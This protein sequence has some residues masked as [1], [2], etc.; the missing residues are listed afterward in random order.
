MSEDATE[1]WAERFSELVRGLVSDF[2]DYDDKPAVE[3]GMQRHSEWLTYSLTDLEQK[4][5]DLDKLYANPEVALFFLDGRRLFADPTVILLIEVWLLQPDFSP[6]TFLPEGHQRIAMR[7]RELAY[8]LYVET[9]ASLR[10]LADLLPETADMLPDDWKLM[11]F[12][13]SPWLVYV[14]ERSEKRRLGK[15]APF[16]D[17]AQI[18]FDE[19]HRRRQFFGNIAIG[20]ALKRYGLARDSAS[21]TEEEA[22][23]FRAPRVGPP[24]ERKRWWQRFFG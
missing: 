6:P 24:F 15:E 4:W 12:P 23:R 8:Q 10:V 19:Y 17:P 3:R 9:E 11:A 5:N 2:S 18:L 13:Y 20:G 14:A 7:I 1:R 16:Q 21:L 22:T